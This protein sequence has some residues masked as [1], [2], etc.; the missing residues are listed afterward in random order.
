[1][2]ALP[3]DIPEMRFLEKDPE[4]RGYVRELRRYIAMIPEDDF[5]TTYVRPSSTVSERET[6]KY[7]RYLTWKVM[8]AELVV[9]MCFMVGWVVG[10]DLI[11]WFGGGKG[12][13][14]PTLG[15]FATIA[16]VALG[17]VAVTSIITGFVYLRRV[18]VHRP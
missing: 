13:L 8:V 12:V 3:A 14:H 15:L 17:L 16:A 18:S 4:L 7:F 6:R 11:V 10:A 1:M 5:R 2:V 9:M